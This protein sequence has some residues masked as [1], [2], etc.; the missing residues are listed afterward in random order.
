MQTCV[1]LA[2][3]SALLQPRIARAIANIHHPSTYEEAGAFDTSS[4]AYAAS[5]PTC[6]RTSNPARGK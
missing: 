4:K 5:C 2:R 3:P 1:G 6:G